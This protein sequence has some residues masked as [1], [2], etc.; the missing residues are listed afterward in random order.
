MFAR[1]SDHFVKKPQN[2]SCPH[3]MLTSTKSKSKR[4]K[5]TVTTDAEVDVDAVFSL[6]KKIRRRIDDAVDSFRTDDKGL[7]DFPAPSEMKMYFSSCS[8]D[9]MSSD[10]ESICPNFESLNDILAPGKSHMDFFRDI[11]YMESESLGMNHY[12]VPL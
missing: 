5:P 4:H 1:T 9:S 8:D 3:M 2:G 6:Y 12:K 10:E 7:D 11:I